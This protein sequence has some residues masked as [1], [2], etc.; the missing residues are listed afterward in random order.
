VSAW[1]F[2]AAAAA[3]AG[4][5]APDPAREFDA[6]LRATISTT[7]T[8]TRDDSG[9]CGPLE[10][11]S[12]GGRVVSIATP[13]PRRIRIGGRLS[14]LKG[15]VRSPGFAEL[16]RCTGPATA[17]A[18]IVDCLGA[19]RAL[20]NVAVSITRPR[21]DLLRLAVVRLPR[22]GAACG[23]TNELRTIQRE[24]ARL[25]LAPI[26]FDPAKLDSPRT[27]RLTLRRTYARTVNLSGP[28]VGQASI[29]VSWVLTLRPRRQR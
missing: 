17:V 13:R 9:E 18:Q 27:A 10:S 16:N 1:G 22:T 4:L 24:R 19:R 20:S 28:E 29:R 21:R 8:W 5:A 23:E 3:L 26:V 6:T 2:A 25:D 11:R 7:W 12:E 15:E 14:G